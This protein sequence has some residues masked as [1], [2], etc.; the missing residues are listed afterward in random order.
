MRLHANTKGACYNRGAAAPPHTETRA[1]PRWRGPT[2]VCITC[3]VAVDH[4][5]PAAFRGNRRVQG[6]MQ[7]TACDAGKWVIGGIGWGYTKQRGTPDGRRQSGDD[8]SQSFG[9]AKEAVRAMRAYA[10]SAWAFCT[11]RIGVL[12]VRVEGRSHLC[13]DE[14]PLMCGRMR[15]VRCIGRLHAHEDF[16]VGKNSRTRSM[17]KAGRERTT[18]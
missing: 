10:C 3:C 18:P 13:A 11:A 15:S 1:V 2:V 9:S 17:G 7:G 6:I 12:H 5:K 4:V 14:Q 16:C 8:V